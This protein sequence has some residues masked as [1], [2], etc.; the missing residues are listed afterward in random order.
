MFL[1]DEVKRK[2]KSMGRG[3][4][5]HICVHTREGGGIHAIGV[6][7]RFFFPFNHYDRGGERGRHAGHVARWFFSRFY[8]TC[9]LK[10]WVNKQM[11]V[12]EEAMLS[13]LPGDLPNDDEEPDSFHVIFFLL[14]FIYYSFYLIHALLPCNFF[15]V[16]I[17]L[18]LFYSIHVLL[19]CTFFVTICLLLLLLNPCTP[20]IFCFFCYYSFITPFT[21]FMYS[22]HVLVF[23]LLFVCYWFAGWWRGAHDAFHALAKSYLNPKP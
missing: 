13:L 10:K 2:Q 21:Q 6:A 7:R 1:D 17:C 5:L 19:P 16:T 12:E 8:F 3:G 15:L 23:L 4:P 11:E 20:S 22:F 18:L 14:L 9:K